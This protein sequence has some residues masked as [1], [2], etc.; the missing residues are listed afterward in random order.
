MKK[1]YLYCPPLLDV[2][3]LYQE[4]IV[5]E[6]FTESATGENFDDLTEID[7]LF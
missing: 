7:D 6:S 2:V 4:S 3:I 5:C 1:K